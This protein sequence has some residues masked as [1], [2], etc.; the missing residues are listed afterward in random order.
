MVVINFGL[1]NLIK[2]NTTL[3]IVN[4]LPECIQ[5]VVKWDNMN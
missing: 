2:Q 5:F 1:F 3:V 4:G